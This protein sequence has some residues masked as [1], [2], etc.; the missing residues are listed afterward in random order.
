MSYTFIRMLY[1]RRIV[2]IVL[3]EDKNQADKCMKHWRGQVP[4]VSM[5][6]MALVACDT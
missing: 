3:T 1:G 2:L 4:R 5:R 6:P